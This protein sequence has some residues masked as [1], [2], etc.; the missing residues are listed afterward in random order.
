MKKLFALLLALMM[1]FSLAAC[2]DNNTTDP[3]KDNP[4]VSQSGENNESQGGTENQGGEENNGGGEENNGG[5]EENN[6][7]T[8][9]WPTADYIKDYMEYKGNGTIVYVKDD[10]DYGGYPATWVYI[11]GVTLAEIETYISAIKAEGFAYHPTAKEITAGKGEP[12]VEF[13][14]YDSSFSWQGQLDGT[15]YIGLKICESATSGSDL[16]GSEV[17]EFTYNLK[18][19]ITTGIAEE[20]KVFAY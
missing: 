7:K 1:I 19:F 10:S 17:V 16:V 9:S 4:G 6:A 20:G 11:N 2:G 3:D 5:G 12:T 18:L 14:G 13:G 8:Y 15:G